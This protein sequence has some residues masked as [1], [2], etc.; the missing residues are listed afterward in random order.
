MPEQAPL[1]STVPLMVL[2]VVS[3]AVPEKEIL[4]PV[5]PGNE[6]ATVLPVTEPVTAVAAPGMSQIVP[7]LSPWAVPESGK[8][9]PFMTLLSARIAVSV[10]GEPKIMKVP[11]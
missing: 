8:P 4:P 6:N 2:K 1:G 5:V 7:L 3:V 10:I 9:P 11:A